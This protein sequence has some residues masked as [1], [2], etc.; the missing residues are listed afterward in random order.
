MKVIELT[1]HSAGNDRYRFY[2][3]SNLSKDL[4]Q[5]RKRT[6][7]LYLENIPFQTHT[8]CGPLDWNNMKKK[9][10]KGYDLYSLK[11]SNWIID[12][13]MHFKN[14]DNKCRKV[15]FNVIIKGEIIEL[16]KI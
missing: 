13:K 1:I 7:I 8:T 12:N 11:I 14:I 10:K 2:I 6:V 15:S 5:K 16:F 3:P 4:F 9:Q